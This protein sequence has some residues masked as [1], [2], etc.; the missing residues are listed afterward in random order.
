M[1]EVAGDAAPGALPSR[2]E[3]GRDGDD[4]AIRGALVF[5][6]QALIAPRVV[7]RPGA[8]AVEDE[9]VRAPRW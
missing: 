4:P 7:G 8:A 1:P 3:N 5:D 6:R 2:E 9:L